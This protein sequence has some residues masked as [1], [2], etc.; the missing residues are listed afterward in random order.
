MNEEIVQIKEAILVLASYTEG[1]AWRV[2][3]HEEKKAG[4]TILKEIRKILDK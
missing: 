4:M 2:S 3:T 1:I